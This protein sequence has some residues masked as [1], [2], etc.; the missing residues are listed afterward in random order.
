MTANTCGAST[1]SALSVPV[2]V[3]L[4]SGFRPRRYAR[5]CVSCSTILPRDAAVTKAL[6]GTITLSCSTFSETV[7][8]EGLSAVPATLTASRNAALSVFAV[9]RSSKSA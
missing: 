7:A 1:W 5:L 8:F 2:P 3:P 4:T 6:S 9:S